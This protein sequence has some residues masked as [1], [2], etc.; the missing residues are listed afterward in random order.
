[1]EHPAHLSKQSPLL[2]YTPMAIALMERLRRQPDRLVPHDFQP[3]HRAELMDALT[4]RVYEPGY[5]PRKKRMTMTPEEIK[6]WI[7]GGM[8]YQAVRKKSWS[9]R[10]SN[11]VMAHGNYLD[12]LGKG[13]ARADDGEQDFHSVT[14]KDSILPGGYKRNSRGAPVNPEYEILLQYGA[15]DGTGW[16]WDHGPNP[17]ATLIVFGEDDY[18]KLQMAVVTKDG[19]T[20][21]PGGMIDPGENPTEAALRE[22]KEEIGFKDKNIEIFS[23][24]AKILGTK[25]ATLTAWEENQSIAVFPH[26]RDINN[27][28]L[29]HDDSE[30]G[31]PRWV[32]VTTDLLHKLFLPHANDVRLAVLEYE[33]REGVRIAPD[34]SIHKLSTH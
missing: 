32:T 13:L 28:P 21:A 33:R 7:N 14:F 2:Y 34:G 11:L 15:V 16:Y 31:N 3:N 4:A 24:P 19:R 6:I 17:S 18:N 27:H 26:D 1:L 12:G 8:D 25:R 9:G 5:P 20:F 29:S 30:I 22:G 10:V 23:L